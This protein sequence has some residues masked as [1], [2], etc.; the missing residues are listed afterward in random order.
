[1]PGKDGVE[2]DAIARSLSASRGYEVMHGLGHAV[3]LEIHEDPRLSETSTDTLATGNV[4]TV[5]PGVY[6]A[7]VGGVRIEDLV[8]VGEGG[9]R[10]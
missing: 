3:G 2:V 4:V 7:G 6:L 1:M 9:P 5:E 8:I 10:C